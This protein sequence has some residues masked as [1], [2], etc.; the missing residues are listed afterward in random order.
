M[1][2]DDLYRKRQRNLRKIKSEIKEL[3]PL[4]FFIVCREKN[5]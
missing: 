5:R 4:R 2:F 3:E 1:G